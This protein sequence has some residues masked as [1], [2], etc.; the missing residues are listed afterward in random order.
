MQ[1]GHT[2]HKNPCFEQKNIAYVLFWLLPLHTIIIVKTK[3]KLWLAVLR[4]IWIISDVESLRS[5]AS[6]TSESRMT[7]VPDYWAV[8]SLCRSACERVELLIRNQSL[9]WE[10]NMWGILV[11]FQYFLKVCLTQTTLKQLV[12]QYPHYIVYCTQ[13]QRTAFLLQEHFHLLNIFNKWG[14]VNSLIPLLN[15]GILTHTLFKC[16]FV[17]GCEALHV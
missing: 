17:L 6:Q 7:L 13:A 8:F 5:T 9:V 15:V 4:F 1:E 12:N 10:E 16:A 2:S 11:S 14:V 3:L